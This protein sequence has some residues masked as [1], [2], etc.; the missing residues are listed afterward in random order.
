[1]KKEEALALLGQPLSVF[2]IQGL[3]PVHETWTYQVPFG[4]S[5]TLQLEGG[6]VTAPPR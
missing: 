3:N 5:V 2:S 6:V 1:M 4:K